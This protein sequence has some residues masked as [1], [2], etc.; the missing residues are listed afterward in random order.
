MVE[1]LQLGCPRC[2]E[3]VVR[4]PGR[5]RPAVWCSQD[6]R[7]A[8]SSERLRAS[9]SGQPVQVVE[10]SRVQPEGLDVAVER[11]LASPKAIRKV[12]EG[13][14][15]QIAAGQL[16]AHAKTQIAP[17]V[18]A[19]I[20]GCE[21]DVSYTDQLTQTRSSGHTNAGRAHLN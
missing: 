1:Q 10:V 7:R 19:M 16:P 13:T 6:C 18:L 4:K 15:A 11:V 14:G 20:K 5:G 12:L 3:P 2:G 8:A 9:R 21:T 17:G